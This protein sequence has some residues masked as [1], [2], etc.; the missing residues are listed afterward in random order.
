MGPANGRGSYYLCI[1]QWSSKAAW[2]GVL[3]GLGPTS[4]L[5][6]KHIDKI[7]LERS[8]GVRTLPVLLGERPARVAA[9]L[10][11]ISQYTGC[12]ALVLSGREH[13]FLLVVLLN[14]GALWRALGVF[15]TPKPTEKP[16]H[17]PGNLW[18]LWFAPHAFAHQRRFTVLFL[19]ALLLAQWMPV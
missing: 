15:S 12:I 10:L 19:A 8:K 1:G 2:L 4:V 11:L 18:P 17:F 5:F 13:G 16:E 9:K 3:Y 6:G 7:D 14:L